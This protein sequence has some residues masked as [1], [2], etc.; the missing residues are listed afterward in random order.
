MT[1]HRM[2]DATLEGKRRRV[3]FALGVT[4]ALVNVISA[5]STYVVAPAN[6]PAILTMG[7]LSL[8]FLAF[9][10][11]ILSGQFTGLFTD[12]QLFWDI[13]EMER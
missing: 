9:S 1:D 13:I 8:V 7:V 12:D 6:M 4:T 5:V 2:F 10:I 11:S 3:L